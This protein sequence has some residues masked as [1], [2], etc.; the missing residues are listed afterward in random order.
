MDG[1]VVK[2]IGQIIPLSELEHTR[3]DAL[4]RPQTLNPGDY[5]LSEG[6]ICR[7]VAFIESGLLRYTINHN[8]EDLT[9]SF[10]KEGEFASNYESFLDQSVSTHAIQAIEP[11][12]LRCISHDDLQRLY[13][14]VREGERFGRLTIE[15]VF[16]QTIRQLTDL[17]TNSPEARYLQFREHF[18]AIEQRV[19]QYYVASYV[20]VKPQSLSRIRR[21]LAGRCAIINSGALMPAFGW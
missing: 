15:Q 12:R 18:R 1:S 7:Y 8:G 3:I 2:A 19:P 5:W 21:R 13:R 14:E 6:Q 9:Y 11:T 17:Y 20:G 10:G 16:L 4:F